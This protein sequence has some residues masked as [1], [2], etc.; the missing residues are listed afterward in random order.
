MLVQL[1]Y[2]SDASG[3][4]TKDNLGQFYTY[5]AEGRITSEGSTTYKYDADGQ[6]V[7]ENGSHGTQVFSRNVAGQ[8]VLIF[9]PSGCCA[10]YAAL[11]AYID[12][13]K[14]GSW[15]HDTFHFTGQ[16]WLG[17]K[18]YESGGNGDIAST[19]VPTFQA[20]FTSLPFGDMLNSVSTD[21]THFTDKERDVESGLD[22][23]GARYYSSST[24]RFMSP[25]PSGLV[26]AD[27]KNPQSLNLY[28][29]AQNNPLTNVDPTG[30][31]CVYFND[32]GNGIESD[33]HNSNSGECGQNGGDWVNGTVRSAQYFADSDTFGFRSNDSSNNYLTYATAPGTQSDGTTCAGNCDTANGYFQSSNGGP[34][35][36]PL[37]PYALG[38]IQGVAQQTA[39][40]PNVCG[41]GVTARAG[42]PG[43][44][45]SAG[46]DLSSQNGINPAG[47][48]RI[49]QLG[50]V[51]GSV[52]VKGHSVSAS[53]TAP[54]PGT[55]F[56]GGVSTKGSG[57]S[58]VSVGMRAGVVNV[59][60]YA[61][62][63][64]MGSCP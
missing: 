10:P 57:I 21:P 18:R 8:A 31:D 54:I 36:V 15:Q 35:D 49:A 42:I 41:V 58:S 28:S 7:Y 56:V 44:R 55:P 64:T 34:Q 59:Q 53:V 32:A 1:K 30:L 12:G 50:N 13:Q 27:P 38:V 47:G 16:D 24:G 5:D 20:S 9:N 4:I 2:Q 43:S 39:W 22:Y 17:T 45:L 11:A 60:E 29:Y 40:F 51:Q 61:N 14:V 63:G 62:V 33:D 6:L 48:A 52:S 46:V 19:A 26:Y 37:N 25:D 3:N 23:F